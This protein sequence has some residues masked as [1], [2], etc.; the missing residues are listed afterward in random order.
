MTNPIDIIADAM[1]VADG[2]HTMG[3]GRLAEVAAGALDS[4]EIAKNA[5]DAMIARGY[6]EFM[7]SRQMF[8]VARTVLRS[9]GGA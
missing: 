5:V 7:T 6:G 1:R 3:T 9:V 4:E 2:N 8:D